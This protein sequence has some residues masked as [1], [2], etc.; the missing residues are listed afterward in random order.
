MKNGLLTLWITVSVA[1]T[2]FSLQIFFLIEIIS[3]SSDPLRL[4]QLHNSKPKTQRVPLKRD[5]LITQP[6]KKFKHD[7]FR[8]EETSD[9][10]FCFYT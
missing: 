1:M 8:Y 6:K 4:T 10:I 3:P 5:T 2:M 7:F 9:N